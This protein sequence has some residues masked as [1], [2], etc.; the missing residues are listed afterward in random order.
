MLEQTVNEMQ[1]DLI[2]MRQASAQVSHFLSPASVMRSCQLV[3]VRGE[4]VVCCQR[5]LP[6][7]C[8]SLSTSR[9]QFS[10]AILVTLR[11]DFT[12]PLRVECTVGMCIA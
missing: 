9:E 2:K 4:R 5:A 7:V 3:D 11:R 6:G 10:F 1:E 8:L 12:D